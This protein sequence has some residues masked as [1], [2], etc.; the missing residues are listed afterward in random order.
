MIFTEVL[1]GISSKVRGSIGYVV[2]G[3]D[4]I[5]IDR[6]V[7]ETG[8][9]FD[10]LATESTMLLRTTRQAADEI[11]AG[12]LK[13][14]SFATAELTVVAVAITDEYVLLGA[15]RNGS[16]F[17]KARFHMKRAAMQL[18]KELV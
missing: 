1:K 9:N 12:A 6:Y 7:A 8:H 13:E 18:E 2:M 4:G 10:M 3:M 11:G 15:L 5:P 17:G 14:V 16:N